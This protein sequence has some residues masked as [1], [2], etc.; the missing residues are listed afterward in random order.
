M[1]IVKAAQQVGLSADATNLRLK[2]L[3]KQGVI[4]RFQTVVDF[5]PL[6]Y[7]LYSVYLKVD[8]YSQKRETQIQTF[9]YTLPNITFAERIL[10]QWDL[11]IQVSVKTVQEFEEVLKKIRE[12]L[13]E[14][15]KYYN[16]ALMLNEHK[17]VSYILEMGKL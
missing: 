9:F 12:F 13:S 7:L 15:L 1:S 8:N 10:G 4:R 5:F 6:N 2:K 3:V 14:D 11:R 16:S 17:R